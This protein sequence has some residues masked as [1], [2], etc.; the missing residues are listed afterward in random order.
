[1]FPSRKI[2]VQILILTTGNWLFIYKQRNI[3]S[4]NVFQNN[5]CFF[6]YMR[7]VPFQYTNFKK[8]TR[9]A[10]IFRNFTKEHYLVL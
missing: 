3:T 1:M 4:F 10:V 8:A 7:I 2:V 5:V 9:F 6:H